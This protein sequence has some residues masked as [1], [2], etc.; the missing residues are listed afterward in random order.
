MSTPSLYSDRV[1]GPISRTQ[2]E[3]PDNTSA[4]LRGLVQRRIEGHWLAEEF[5]EFCADGNGIAGTNYRSVEAA[6]EALIPDARW[7]ISEEWLDDETVF[8]ILE[9]VGQHVA[10][11]S[12]GRN[13]EF[14]RHHEL[15]FNK[16]DGRA[17]FRE[18]VN[19]ILA[20]GGTVYEMNGAMQ[21]QRV[22]SPEVQAALRTLRPA[23]GDATLDGLLETA[24]T[25]YLSRKPADRANAIE[26]LWDGFERLKSI[27]DP[28]DKKNSTALLLGNIPDAA[29]RDVIETEMFALTKLGNNF[30]IRHHEVGK[31]AIPADAQDY[32]ATR[33]VNLIVF[34]LD[35]SGRLASA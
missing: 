19:A 32:F 18:E 27:D 8:D 13:H 17:E 7:P 14:L 21:I 1:N 12:N 26:K 34:L 11:P 29:L 28:T 30:Q 24:R 25:L 6:I 9:Y 4:G 2:E 10:K 20:R 31:H 16:K 22:G 23:T 33:M 5:P 35:Q 3:L 15:N